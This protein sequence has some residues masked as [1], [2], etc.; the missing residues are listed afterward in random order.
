MPLSLG[1]RVLNLSRGRPVQLEDEAAFSGGLNTVSA[2][3]A[4][5]ANQ[6]R[7]GS[8]CRLTSFGAVTKRGGTQRTAAAL[9]AATGIQNGYPWYQAAGTVVTMAVCG[10]TLFTTSY[11]SFPLTW[12]QRG[13]TGALSTTVTPSLAQF[14]NA[15]GVESVYI[16]DGGLLNRYTGTTLTTNIAGTPSVNVLCVHNQRLWGCGDASFPDSIWYS[17]LN[18]GDTLGISG[19]SG[20]QIVVRTFGDQN[21]IG[22]ASLGTSLMIFHTSGVSRLTGYGQDDVTVS[23]AG[24]TGDVGSIAPFSIVR[25][26]NVVYF[27]SERGLYVAT[28][29]DVAPVSTPE[30]PDPLSVILPQMSSANIAN[31][32]AVLNRGTRELWIQIPGYGVYLYHTILKAWCGPFEDGYQSPETAALFET[33]N[34]SNYPIV[35]RG[36][37]SGFVSECDRPNVVLDN[38]AAD[39]TGG[40][41]YAMTLQCR[42]MY[43][44]DPHVAKSWR[45]A[46][47]LA[48]LNGSAASSLGWAT[49]SSSGTIALP[50]SVASAWGASGTSWGSGMWGA[51]AQTS[52]R[53]DPDGWGYFID[54][55]FTDSG[56]ALPVISQARVLGFLMGRR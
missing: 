6:F 21:V 8:N 36:D 45:Y 20:G 40:T 27:T 31:I 28:E 49:Q 17:A 34:A 19:S 11:G 37:S 55:T 13:A 4:L 26:N 53:V 38:V 9:I 23:P 5:A 22:L 30:Q 24:V 50:V 1:R 39:G 46:F 47:L 3:D 18:N 25:V 10:G 2:P 44:S 42:R 56:A 7:R 12:T 14:L 41:S 54:L 33:T 15:G 16:A 35:L 52:Y 43:T 48:D 29:Q 32:R 51:A